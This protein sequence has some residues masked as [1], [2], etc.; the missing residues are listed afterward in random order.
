[1]SMKG[2]RVEK[3]SREKGMDAGISWRTLLRFYTKV[4]I[5]WL[6]L[7]VVF[8]MSFAVKEA[9]SALVPYSSAIMTGEIMGG[10]FLVGFLFMNL[11]YAFVEAF[12]GSFNEWTG[13]VVARNVRRSVWNKLIRLPM[14]ALD[15]EDSQQLVSRV[16]QDTTGAYA[17]LAA[18]IQFWAVI[19][20]VYTNWIKMYR[21]YKSVSLVMLSAI[22]LTIVISWACGKLQ[23]SMERI[24]NAGY[25]AVTGF[26][27]ERLPN[28]LHIK[29][30]R[31]E[32]QE[33]QKGVQANAD[34]YKADIRR[35]NR[36]IFQG[37]VGSL[38]Q[39]INEIILLVVASAMVRAGAMK[40]PQ[41]VNL[42]NYFL[43]F[44][45]NA[46]MITAVWQVLKQSHGACATIARLNA[47]EDEKMDGPVAVSQ[48]APQDITFENVHYSYEPGKE[49]LKGVN[50][51]IPAGKCTAIVGENGCGKSTVIRLLERFADPDSGTIRLNGADMHTVNLA[52]WR[53]AVAYL[54]QGEQMVQGTIREN[55]LYGLDREVSD[56]EIEAAARKACAWDFIQSRDL[57]LDSVVSR[58][59]SKLSGGEQQR[60]AVA[61]AILRQPEYL[62]MDEATSGI[63][64]VSEAEILGNL[65]ESM[66]G[67]TVI[68]V[69]HDMRL[70][71]KADHVI[72][73][74]DGV[75][76]ASGTYEEGLAASPLLRQLAAA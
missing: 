59:D 19:Y 65:W 36:F 25:A 38:S 47:I 49:I 4:K 6:M 8:L 75:V 21:V 32:D 55:L 51:T 28:L 71:Q 31:M 69:S 16:T 22:P 30:C 61:R 74:K 24:T 12:Q 64:V 14:S 70:I 67:K 27:A 72:V 13:Q 44:M 10:N 34:K 40:Q 9:E 68:M 53:D 41:L 3:K 52:Q 1:M 26:F 2:K 62:I 66:Q 20:G 39:Y 43:L 54:Y 73:L 18:L 17:A 5:P 56:S 35:L 50:F 11:M 57:G 42:Y 46:F 7:L 23:Y 48:E 33:Y 63:D 45:G 60:L 15:K 58:F 29:T 37:P 76:E